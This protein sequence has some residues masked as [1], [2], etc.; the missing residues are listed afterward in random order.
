[1]IIRICFIR[2]FQSFVSS[3]LVLNFRFF[4]PSTA[5]Q[6]SHDRALFINSP[7]GLAVKSSYINFFIAR[8]LRLKTKGSNK[9]LRIEHSIAS[10]AEPETIFVEIAFPEKLF[11]S[12]A[13][14][15]CLGLCLHSL[16]TSFCDFQVY[17]IHDLS[18]S[19]PA[20]LGSN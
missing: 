20:P 19:L 11:L 1:M 12:F 14:C 5:R 17:N 3:S 18:F 15:H 10:G 6:L 2:F 4:N 9:G 16:H 8:C 7:V 13:K